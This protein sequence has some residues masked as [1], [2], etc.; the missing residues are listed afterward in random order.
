MRAP[1]TLV[2]VVLASAQPALAVDQC[3]GKIELGESHHGGPE[4]LVTLMALG[5]AQFR[6]CRLPQ[7]DYQVLF[8]LAIENGPCERE[9]FAGKALARGGQTVR[10]HLAGVSDQEIDA[11]FSANYPGLMRPQGRMKKEEFCRGVAMMHEELSAC[12]HDPATCGDVGAP[13]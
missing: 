8:D 12:I 7:L 10:D 13:R 6:H 5:A 9:T 1:A 11:E 4:Y 2:C 3:D